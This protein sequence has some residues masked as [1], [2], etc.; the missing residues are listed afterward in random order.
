M[1]EVRFMPQSH[2]RAP[3]LIGELAFQAPKALQPIGGQRFRSY[4]LEH[5]AAGLVLVRAVAEVAASGELVDLGESRR[6]TRV[7]AFRPQGELPH[8]GG[9]DEQSSAG[10]DA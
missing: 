6:G 7:V 2:V 9:V 1:P 8:A 3:A 4:G 10:Q 5:R